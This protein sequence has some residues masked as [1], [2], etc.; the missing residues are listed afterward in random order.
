MAGFLLKTKVD[1]SLESAFQYLH[2][3]TILL[4]LIP[5]GAKFKFSVAIVITTIVIRQVLNVNS[6]GG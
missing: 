5:N 3:N 1:T 4:T 6:G 2:V